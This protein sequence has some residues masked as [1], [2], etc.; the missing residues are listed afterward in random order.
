MGD[1]ADILGLESQKQD[2]VSKLLNEKTRTASKS[3]VKPK[4]VSRELYALMGEGGLA[5]S[6]QTNT[7]NV[8]KDKRQRSLQGK[9]VWAPFTN[10]AR[11]FILN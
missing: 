1:V 8:F 9:W 2:E 5:P 10:P 11:R 7:G 3:K 4:G 6:I